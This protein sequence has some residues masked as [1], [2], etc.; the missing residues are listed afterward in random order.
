[1]YFCCIFNNKQLLK[2]MLILNLNIHKIVSNV[3]RL[4]KI[5]ER[6]SISVYI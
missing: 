2:K 1:M 5:F 4:N 6:I 3:I